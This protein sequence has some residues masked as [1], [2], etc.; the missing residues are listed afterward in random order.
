M[1]AF[2]AEHTRVY[3]RTDGRTTRK[4]NASKPNFFRLA[5]WLEQNY[6]CFSAKPRTA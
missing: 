4:H 3:V 5:G 6:D 1:E 2:S